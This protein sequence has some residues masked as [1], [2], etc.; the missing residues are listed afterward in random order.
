MKGKDKHT[1]ESIRIEAYL[2]SEKAGHPA[3][4]DHYFWTQA[5]AIVSARA[6]AV[7]VAVKAAA[8]KPAAKPRAATVTKVEAKPKAE[9]KPKATRKPALNGANGKAHQLSL[10]GELAAPATRKR[11]VKK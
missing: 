7:S 5:E 2:L 1:S 9:P 11:T 3:G 10:N 6:V 4:M 8:V